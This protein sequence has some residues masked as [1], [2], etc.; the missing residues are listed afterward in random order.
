MK[1]KIT[2]DRELQAKRLSQE[3]SSVR[4]N[5][6]VH[7]GSYSLLPDMDIVV[8][9]PKTCKVVAVISCKVTLRE[10]VAQTAYWKLKLMQDPI[11][12]P[13][14][15]FFVTPD[16]D[17]NLIRRDPPHRNRIIIE[18]DTDGAYVLDPSVE[19]SDKIKRFD[20][21]LDDIANGLLRQPQ[22]SK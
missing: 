21:I 11:T 12:Q 6:L 20:R 13:I 5:V 4:R 16:E 1:L 8:Y 9:E 10:R 15:V 17:K 2:T 7:Y 18:H 3:L 22:S 14:R 19:E